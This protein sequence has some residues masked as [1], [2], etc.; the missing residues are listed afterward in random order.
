MPFQGSVVIYTALNNSDKIF[1]VIK[2]KDKQSNY[3][4]QCK[5]Q[6]LIFS[7]QKKK[8]KT[9]AGETIYKKLSKDLPL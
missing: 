4:T 7:V 9:F 2:Y 8:K 1:Q 3:L 5:N 6:F